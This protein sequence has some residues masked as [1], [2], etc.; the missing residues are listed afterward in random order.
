M[1]ISR[2]LKINRSHLALFCLAMAGAALF[3]IVL[4]G[5]AAFAVL[6]GGGLPPA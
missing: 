3:W 2:E 4:I 5:V 6:A 1:P